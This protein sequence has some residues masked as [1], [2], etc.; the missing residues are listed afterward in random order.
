[1]KR[2]KSLGRGLADLLCKVDD[3][4]LEEQE[5]PDHGHRVTIVSIGEIVS[6]ASQP[7]KYFDEAAL[8]TLA[9][10]IAQKGLISPITV[11]KIGGG[12][13]EIIAGERRFKAAKIAG[14]KSVPVIIKEADNTLAFELSIIENIQREDLNAVEEAEAYQALIDKYSYSQNDIAAKISKSRSHIA[15]M[16]RLLSLPTKVIALIKEGKLSAGHAKALIGRDDAE[17]LVDEIV[18]NNLNVRATER[19]TKKNKVPRVKTAAP[20]DA[21]SVQTDDEIA[22]LEN[23]LKDKLGM[24]VRIDHGKKY[25]TIWYEDLGELDMVLQLLSAKR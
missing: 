24:Q 23:L 5:I 10:S 2:E 12:K 18:A 15:N 8:S 9:D 11:R 7:R 22:I 19:L 1:M 21:G 6:N 20:S 3:E 13:L 16:L 14:L 25:L 4:V 17:Q